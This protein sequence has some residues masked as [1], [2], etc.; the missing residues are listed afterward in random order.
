MKYRILGRT[1]LKVSEIGY[2]LSGMSNWTG[3]DGA[4]SYAALQSSLELGCNF[5]DTAWDYGQGHS[6]K[7]LG[8]LIKDNPGKEIIVADKIPPKKIQDVPLG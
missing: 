6:D 8:Q 7:L 3:S 2:G 5:F 1:G 4:Q